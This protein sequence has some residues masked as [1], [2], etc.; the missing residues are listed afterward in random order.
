[1]STPPHSQPPPNP[2]DDGNTANKNPESPEL[3]RCIVRWFRGFHLH[4]EKSKVTDWVGVILTLGVAVAAFWSA[5]VFQDQLREMRT[6]TKQSLDSFRIDE[7]ASVGLDK[8]LIAEKLNFPG[9]SFTRSGPDGTV[10][11]PDNPNPLIHTSLSLK[12]FGKTPAFNVV[13]QAFSSNIDM[14]DVESKTMCQFAE[15][16]SSG[17]AVR[18]GPRQDIKWETLGVTIFPG[19]TF[20]TPKDVPGGDIPRLFI[21]GCIA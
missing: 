13:A 19:Q 16:A 5:W 20:V 14:I 15:D 17:K 7:Q 10:H 9:P 3:P 6:Q 4:R 1:M 11:Q 8:P 18:D 21:V 2:K 12:N